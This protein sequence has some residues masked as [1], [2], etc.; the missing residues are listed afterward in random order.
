MNAHVTAGHCGAMDV[1]V[2]AGHCGGPQTSCG[3]GCPKATVVRDYLFPRQPQVAKYFNR[4]S[5]QAPVTGAIHSPPV[6]SVTAV[7]PTADRHARLLVSIPVASPEYHVNT[8]V[9]MTTR[10]ALGAYLVSLTGMRRRPGAA[11]VR[12]AISLGAFAQLPLAV[13]K[14]SGL[15][16]RRV[17]DGERTARIGGDLKGRR[18]PSDRITVEATAIVRG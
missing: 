12:G 15:N 13:P 5:Q 6:V 16:Y 17:E 3:R 2:A 7:S 4:M 11:L 8:A 14:I 1:H 18:G 10:I 9:F